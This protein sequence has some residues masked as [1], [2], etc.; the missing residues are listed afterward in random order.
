MNWERRD[1]LDHTD[2]DTIDGSDY[3]DSLQQPNH[4][5]IRSKDVLSALAY[6]YGLDQFLLTGTTSTGEPRQLDRNVLADCFLALVAA[7]YQDNGIMNEWLEDLILPVLSLVLECQGVKH[8]YDTHQEYTMAAAAKNSDTSAVPP[9]PNAEAPPKTPKAQPHTPGKGKQTPVLDAWMELYLPGQKVISVSEIKNHVEIWAGEVLLATASGK[10]KAEAE[11]NAIEAALKK[12]EAAES[13]T[14]EVEEEDE[15]ART[16]KRRR[17]KM[18]GEEEEEEEPEEGDV[19][20]GKDKFARVEGWEMSKHNK[21]EGRK[22]KRNKKGPKR[23]GYMSPKL[24][25]G[26][27][28]YEV[29]KE[30]RK[31]VDAATGEK[32][33][34][35]KKT[36]KG[37]EEPEGAKWREEG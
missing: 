25:K 29:T 33:P 5:Q 22:D 10:S 15:G 8:M 30:K 11:K 17:K 18:D 28:E 12:L 13:S 20:E 26:E 36:E 4:E 2:P 16:K 6:I 35:K 24:H 32:I 27:E 31:A 34:K 37:P 19:F 21:K 7:I 1:I 3:Q 23:R 9:S 14:T